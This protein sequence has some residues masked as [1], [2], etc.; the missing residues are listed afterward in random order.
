LER[1]QSNVV[2]AASDA[3]G[4]EINSQSTVAS[5]SY[6]KCGHARSGRFSTSARRFVL[7]DLPGPAEDMPN[8]MACA[9]QAHAAVLI[10]SA[11]EELQAA[12]EPGVGPLWQRAVMLQAMGIARIIVVI[13]GMEDPHVNWRRDRFEEVQSRVSQLL[14][15][16]GCDAATAA[17]VPVSN[18]M[19]SFLRDRSPDGAWFKGPTLLEHLSALPIP[20]QM[21]TGTTAF[22]PLETEMRGNQSIVLGSVIGGSLRP[23]TKCMVV[24]SRQQCTVQAIIGERNELIHADAG[25]LVTLKVSRPK[26]GKI[27]Q[28][29]ALYTL[30]APEPIRCVTKFRAA[31]H[32]L[33][34]GA[35][36]GAISAGFTA[37]LCAHGAEEQCTLLKFTEGIDLETQQPLASLQV[38]PPNTYVIANLQVHSPMALAVFSKCGA[39]GRF[40]LRARAE[41][42]ILALGKVI[43]LPRNWAD[44]YQQL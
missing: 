19:R 1:F 4:S 12:L 25:E 17:F 8:A 41:D 7:L 15:G 11:A 37:M 40:V 39:L 13:E 14:Q 27:S 18:M 21:K 22:L 38:A 44:R 34:P 10:V 32:I 5:S 2:D 28:N 3:N 30:C 16:L 35:A 20:A 6:L 33:R 31:L 9:A 26:T 23:G 24:P 29:E 36:C 42:T 43:E